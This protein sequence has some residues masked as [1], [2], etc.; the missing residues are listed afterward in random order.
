MFIRAPLAHPPPAP[1]DGVN[2]KS[3]QNGKGGLALILVLGLA[4]TVLIAAPG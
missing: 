4:I 1:V 3:E 2:P